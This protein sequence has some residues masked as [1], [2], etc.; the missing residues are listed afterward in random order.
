LISALNQLPKEQT[1]FSI[2]AIT[3]LG[4]A[5][6]PAS[7]VGESSF[8]LSIGRI[9]AYGSYQVRQGNPPISVRGTLAVNSRT[10]C[11]VIQLAGNGPADE[12]VWRTVTHLCRRGKTN[13]RTGTSYL[14]GGGKPQLRLC[15]G[16]T[17]TKAEEGRHCDVYTPR[18]HH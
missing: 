2:A 6:T 4:L 5:F 10:Q 9:S 18:R 1:M 16:P 15:T 12:I 17:Q 7:P 3:A 8:D 13:Y 11:G 14:W